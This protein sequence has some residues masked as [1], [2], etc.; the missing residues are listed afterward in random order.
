MKI[1]LLDMGQKRFG[2]C[3]VITHANRIIM[4]DGGHP[5]DAASIRFQLSKILNKQPPFQIDLLV[6]THC[7][8]DHIGCL[9]ELI[10]L[11]DIFPKEAL[12]ADEKMGFGIPADDNIDSIADKAAINRTL[13]VAVQE[14]DH[15]DLQDAD[16]EQFLFDAARLVD[17]YS[18]MIKQLESK[19]VK[20]QRFPGKNWTWV[21]AFE[22]RHKDFGLKVLG[23]V[24]EHLALC[25]ES[26][27]KSVSASA[28]GA[29]VTLDL[30]SAYKKMVTEIATD[31][32][33]PGVDRP[34]VGAAKNNQSIVLS[35]EADGWKALLAGDMQFAK[36]E[37]PEL[38]LVM[39][40]LFK[41]VTKAGPYD[42]IKLT[43]HSSYNG[44]NE[45]ILIEWLKNTHAFAHTGGL[46][47]PTHP[48]TG[49]LTLLK[50]HKAQLRYTRTDRNGLIT[51]SKN[52]A[53]IEMATQ[54]GRTNDFTPNLAPDEE[55]ETSESGQF[56][57]IAA[58]TNVQQSEQQ[59][60]SQSQAMVG[61]APQGMIKITAEI[62]NSST[63]VTITIDVDPEKKNFNASIGSVEA[64]TVVIDGSE[65]LA[66]LLFITCSSA[67][68][69]N[70][71]VAETTSI[72]NAV[73]NLPNCRLLDIPYLNKAEEASRHSVNALSSGGFKGVVI[74]GG[75]DVI[76]SRCL[77]T[78]DPNLTAKLKA[79]GKEDFDA[80]NFIVWCDEIYGDKDGDCFAELP[81]SR[82]PDA[83]DAAMIRTSLS[84][85][86][87]NTGERFGIR[88]LKRPFANECYDLI[89]GSKGLEVSELFSS[90][91][92]LPTAKQS[93]LYYMLHGSE[94]DGA[95]FWGEYQAGGY[96]EALHIKN[97][98]HAVPGSIIFTGCCWG[99]LTVDIPAYRFALGESFRTRIPSESIALTYL[100]AGAQA[101]VGCTG[102]HYS[103]VNQPLDNYGKPL[104]DAFWRGIAAGLSPAPA[105]WKAKLQYLKD[106]PH[107][108]KDVIGIAA[109]MKIL[110]QYTCLGLGW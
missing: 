96:P 35:V 32:N 40:K 103:P 64:G 5:G 31:A 34:G 44:I 52:G 39:N 97:I 108:L 69:K 67:L 56:R 55:I 20:L 8:S 15:S 10:N 19:R 109:E 100:K 78:I 38:G 61:E 43:H 17:Q 91:A 28:A 81:V 110:R 51:V 60:V 59:P 54:K 26:I 77:K 88:N 6:V 9:P 3:I 102:S 37:V 94:T 57:E 99:A 29:D 73:R 72:L 79:A 74:I 2:D 23:P 106:M 83:K 48:D 25:A 90:T 46:K 27:A 105:L 76:P 70:I 89:P 101:F 13:F 58:H 80:D 68:S 45:A 95:K 98:P 87:F 41:D 93:A 4:I 18:G 63:R 84:A 7:H 50:K 16:I 65:R 49:T 33:E 42:F 66:G 47:D 104:H 36:A 30:V 85:P 24:A 11:G 92:V 1:H 21:K 14:E 62:P 12:L 53:D 107:G 22:K 86:L 82:I 71:G 75:Y